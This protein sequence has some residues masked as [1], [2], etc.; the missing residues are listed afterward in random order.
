MFAAALLVAVLK[1]ISFSELVY[2][3]DYVCG[4]GLFCGRLQFIWL[5]T[6]WLCVAAIVVVTYF[7]I[8]TTSTSTDTAA[9]V[10]TMTATTR[11]GGQYF[12]KL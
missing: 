5:E 9:G 8:V 1:E 11:G 7:P 12:F 2:F 3:A 6:K 10:A 4:V